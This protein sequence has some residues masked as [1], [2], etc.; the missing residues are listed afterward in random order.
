MKNIKACALA[1]TLALPNYANALDYS[2]GDVDM[3]LHGFGSLGWT[4]TDN[5]DLG[6]IG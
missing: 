4:Q 1:L 3:S 6:F 2:V 5:K